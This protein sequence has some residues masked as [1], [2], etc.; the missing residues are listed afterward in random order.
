MISLHK[1]LCLTYLVSLVIQHD[2]SVFF[3]KVH[4]DDPLHQDLLSFLLLRIEF[5]CIHPQDK[6]LLLP[7]RLTDRR[8]LHP[9][10]RPAGK[11][12]P[13]VPNPDAVC[14][15][16]LH[17]TF[18]HE[19]LQNLTKRLFLIIPGEVQKFHQ[20][21]IRRTS[22]CSCEFLFFLEE[23]RD[24]R[25][26]VWFFIGLFSEFFGFLTVCLHQIDSFLEFRHGKFK[27]LL[28]AA[29]IRI[30]VCKLLF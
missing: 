10:S 12:M 25:Y 24:Q 6:G 13:H 22:G 3:L 20:P 27:L 9:L 18:L 17:P 5:S 30:A 1:L 23:L 26:D 4:V 15:I 14:H 29:S 7:K 16:L 21:V 2:Q 8:I 28:P 11:E 19:I